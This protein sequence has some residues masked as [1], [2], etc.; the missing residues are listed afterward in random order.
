VYNQYATDLGITLEACRDCTD[1]RISQLLQAE[2][3][4]EALKKSNRKVML[5]AALALQMAANDIK[6]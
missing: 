1:R 2:K 4:H 3:D 6:G 5:S